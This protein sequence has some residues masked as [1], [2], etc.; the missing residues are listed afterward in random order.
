M[1][2]T[3][4]ME[5]P[6]M[7]RRRSARAKLSL[8]V[9]IRCSDSNYLEEIGRTLNVSREGLYFVTSARHYLEQYFRNAK[10]HVMRNFRADDLTNLEETGQIVRVEGLPDGKWGVAIHI[11]LG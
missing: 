10:V 4:H 3:N 9:R 1:S 6:L 7:N 2:E 8:P 11:R 5:A